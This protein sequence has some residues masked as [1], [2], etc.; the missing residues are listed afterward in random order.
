MTQSEKVCELT[1][2][3]PF[4]QNLSKVY[5]MMMV[6]LTLSGSLKDAIEVFII[7]THK[8]YLSTVLGVKLPYSTQLFL[9]FIIFYHMIHISLMKSMILT[10]VDR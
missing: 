3:Y 5:V 8:K 4:A 7:N 9:S 10:N 6:V 2:N 1:W